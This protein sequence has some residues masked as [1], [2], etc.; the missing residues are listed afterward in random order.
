[1]ALARLADCNQSC[2]SSWQVARH[3]LSSD[4]VSSLLLA[5]ESLSP[6]FLVDFCLILSVGGLSDFDQLGNLLHLLADEYARL[7]NEQQQYSEVS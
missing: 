2:I 4:T 3:D 1:M 5:A 7:K 6:G